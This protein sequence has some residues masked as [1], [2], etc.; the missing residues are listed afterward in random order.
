MQ[1]IL[2]LD[3]CAAKQGQG[4]RQLDP[5]TAD[6]EAPTDGLCVEYVSASEV[7]RKKKEQRL[8]KEDSGKLLFMTYI[9]F[10]LNERCL[11]MAVILS[12][13][14]SCFDPLLFVLFACMHGVNA[15]ETKRR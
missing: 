4:D 2:N 13:F 5:K 15:F 14:F 6:L 11:C 9:R 3:S 8:L 1:R 12:P 10:T 7:R